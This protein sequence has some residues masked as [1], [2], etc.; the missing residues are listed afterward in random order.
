M[1]IVHGGL[2]WVLQGILDLYHS[3]LCDFHSTRCVDNKKYVIIFIDDSTRF[4]YVYLLHSNYEV[5][6]KFK[7][8][9]T[10]M[11]L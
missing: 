5:L 11:E 7:I 8:Y 10:E 2:T 3:D 6:E 9:K 1:V 4:Y